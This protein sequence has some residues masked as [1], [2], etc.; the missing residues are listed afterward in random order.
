MLKVI[1]TLFALFFA[2]CAK[3]D[4]ISSILPTSIVE[5]FFN[6]L[7]SFQAKFIQIDKSN[8]Q[9]EGTLSLKKV[10]KIRLEYKS[11]PPIIVVVND[12]TL[13]YYDYKREQMSHIP[14]SKTIVSL[15][16]KRVFLFSD[17]DVKLISQKK[18]DDFISISFEKTSMPEEG[19]FTFLFLP[20]NKK[21]PISSTN[22]ELSEIQ[23]ASPQRETT[24][25][26]IYKS[27]INP[28]LSDDLFTIKQIKTQIDNKF[29]D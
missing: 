26:K 22:I 27:T 20:K 9:S 23:I 21:S 6:S 17:S 2:F 1:I 8:N 24:T 11:K 25:L 18:T 28:S 13:S 15:L 19:T 3:A 16:T 7:N 4:D 10:G 5:I 29:K 14:T 12:R